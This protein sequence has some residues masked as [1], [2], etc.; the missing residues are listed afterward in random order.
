MM[1]QATA[2]NRDRVAI[3]TEDMTLTFGQ[4]WGRGV[5]MA[6]A[7]IE[8]G[9]RPGDRVGGLEDNNLGAADLFLGAAIAGAVRVPLYARNSAES[10]AHMIGQTGA[11]VVLTDLAY[12]EGVVDLQA[13]V[14]SLRHVV[15]RD[16]GYEKWLA[17][18][19]DA[20]PYVEVDPDAWY[21]IRHSAGTTGK[22]KG[23]GYTQHDWLV[24]C[25]NWFYRLPNLRWGSVVG[26][27][28]PISHASGYL[29]LAARQH[30]SALR[31]VRPRQCPW[32]DGASPSDAHVRPT[33]DGSDV[34]L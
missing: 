21:I 10:H 34:G 1:R 14:E 7:L 4:M 3:V 23:I 16:E 5:R 19:S 6:N 12:A 33:V 8:L 26:H 28:G 9:V 15:V 11:S 2:L 31:G 25:R 24:N 17:G 32:S 29:F 13:T 22:P 18:Q 27:A 30:E 20:D